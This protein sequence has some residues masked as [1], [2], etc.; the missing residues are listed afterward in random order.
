MKIMQTLEDQTQEISDLCECVEELAGLEA[1][2]TRR[3]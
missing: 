3:D 1:A 2:I